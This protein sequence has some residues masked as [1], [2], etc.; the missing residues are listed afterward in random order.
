MED[1]FVFDVEGFSPDGRL[2]GSCRYTGVRPKCLS[3]FQLYNV[4]IPA[5]VAT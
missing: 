4:A 2:Q 5:W 1:L 3:K